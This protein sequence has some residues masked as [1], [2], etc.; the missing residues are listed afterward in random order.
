ME[1]KNG[2]FKLLGAIILVNGLGIASGFLGVPGE[3]YQGLE[4]SVLTPPSYVFPIA[5]TLIYSMIG[6]SGYLA[7]T[8]NFGIKAKLLF[9]GQLALNYLWTPIFFGLQKPLT[10]LAIISTLAVL[11]AALLRLFYNEEK[12]AAYLLVPYFLWIL[13]A[14][15]LNIVIVIMN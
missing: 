3:W 13:F 1:D 9:I 5:W 4:K 8:R 6:A 7:W 15:Y 10:G 14:T 11:V 12:I 2:L